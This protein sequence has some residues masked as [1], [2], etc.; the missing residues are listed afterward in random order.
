MPPIECDVNSLDSLRGYLVLSFRPKRPAAVSCGRRSNHTRGSN[1]R[2]F[3]IRTKQRANVRGN[4]HSRAAQSDTL[5][6]QLNDENETQNLD[7]CLL[8]G[9]ANIVFVSNAWKTDGD[10]LML[11]VLRC[12]LTY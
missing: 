1:E 9:S 11:Y 12:Q 2:G 5:K 3:S 8:F 6:Q 10:E 7:T 4:L